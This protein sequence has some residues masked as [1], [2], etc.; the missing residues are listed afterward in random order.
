MGRLAVGLRRL[1]VQIQEGFCGEHR[2][3]AVCR[4]GAD[5]SAEGKRVAGPFPGEVD[6]LQQS[7][8][9]KSCSIC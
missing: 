4:A 7:Q 6:A 1:G 3:G 8:M 5:G 9:C 2:T